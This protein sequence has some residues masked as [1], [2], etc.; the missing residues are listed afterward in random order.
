MHLLRGTDSV[1]NFLLIYEEKRIVNN[2]R[3]GRQRK[4]T[5]AERLMS[6][7]PGVKRVVTS[8]SRPPR[9]RELDG[10]DYNFLSTEE[11]ARNIELGNFYEYAKVHDRYYGTPKKSI[12][13]AFAKGGD[14]VLI[15]DVQGAKT[16]KKIAEENPEL[17]ENL[18]TVFIAPHQLK[19]CAPGFAAGGRKAKMR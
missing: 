12:T 3:S 6:E 8:T 2:K 1:V 16:W 9:G 14:L 7:F 4:N 18:I 10:I 5:V 11:F 13:D 17:S 15:I 19:N